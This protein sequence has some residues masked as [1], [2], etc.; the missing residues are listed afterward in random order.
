MPLYLTFCIYYFG[1]ENFLFI[2]KK[3]E[4]ILQSDVSQPCSQI[5]QSKLFLGF[6]F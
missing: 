4:V 6:A 1:Q 2:T 3:S 5:A